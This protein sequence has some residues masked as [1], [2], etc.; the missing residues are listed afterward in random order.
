MLTEVAGAPFR[1]AA[2]A[3]RARAFHPTGVVCAGSARF[4]RPAMDLVT[5]SGADVTIRISKGVGTP[6]GLPDVGGVALRLTVTDPRTDRETL[7]DL[8]PATSSRQAVRLAIPLP[9]MAWTSATFSSLTPFRVGSHLWWLRAELV[10]D[11]ALTDMAPD[12]VRSTVDAGDRLRLVLSHARGPLGRFTPFGSVDLTAARHPDHVDFD[13]IRNAPGGVSMFPD[14]L[15]T[16]RRSSYDQSRSG[17]PD[18]AI[19]PVPGSA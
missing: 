4:S 15:A 5:L 1:W 17:R 10:G 19:S 8:L 7:W 6:R 13:P 12:T 18:T 3:R 2:A 14:W 11:T 9:A 16:L